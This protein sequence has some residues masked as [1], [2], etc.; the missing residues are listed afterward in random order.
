MGAGVVGGGRKSKLVYTLF[1]V[2][3]ISRSGFKVLRT[4]NRKRLVGSGLNQQFQVHT[5][6]VSLAVSNT[7]SVVNLHG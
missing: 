1:S 7:V 3:I 5:Q 4:H 6:L 2:R